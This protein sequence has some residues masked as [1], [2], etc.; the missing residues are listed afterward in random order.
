MSVL[1]SLSGDDWESCLSTHVVFVS[2]DCGLSMAVSR[3]DCVLKGEVMSSKVVVEVQFN[4]RDYE[5]EMLASPIASA[6]K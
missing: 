3:F 1:L 2:H 6:E 5:I 4:A